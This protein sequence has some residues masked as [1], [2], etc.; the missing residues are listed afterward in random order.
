MLTRLRL[1]VHERD[2]HDDIVGDGEADLEV[3]AERELHAEEDVGE[4]G[5]EL[6]VGTGLCDISVYAF[7]H[8]AGFKTYRHQVQGNLLEIVEHETTHLD[9][10]DNGRDVVVE[11]NHR[12]CAYGQHVNIA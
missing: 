1:F 2:G 10:D 4:D 6:R 8:L 9:T 11:Q 7:D 12:R 5:H 3:R